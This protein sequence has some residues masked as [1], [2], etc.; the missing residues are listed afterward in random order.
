MWLDTKFLK[1]AAKAFSDALIAKIPSKKSEIE[2]NLSA[3]NT[4]LTK[5]EAYMSAEL[6]KINQKTFYSYHGVFYYMAK[7]YGLK[8]VNIQVENKTP[9][10]REL[11]GIIKQAKKDKIKVI[12]M[13]AQFNDRPAKMI[14]D[15]TGAKIVKINPLTTDSL[16]ILKSATDALVNAR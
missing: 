3:Y 4:K 5:L 7:A 16:A 12:F 8:E 14:S 10:P 6:S 15:R 9:S 1:L 2:K 11:L 13:Q